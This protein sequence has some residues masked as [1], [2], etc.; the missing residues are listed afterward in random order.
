MSTLITPLLTAF[1]LASPSIDSERP[2]KKVKIDQPVY[3]HL[4]MHSCI[5]D[6]GSED[7]ASPDE[8]KKALLQRIFDAAAAPE[9][10]ESNRRK[11]Y[12]LWREEDD[13]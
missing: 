4:I 3:A 9:A 5:G 6:A 8:L 7:R 12:K 10:V 11:M 2:S 1:T 13:E